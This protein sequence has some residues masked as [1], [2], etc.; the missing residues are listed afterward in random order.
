MKPLLYGAPLSPFVRKVRI[1]MGLKGLEYDSKM[2]V[3]YATPKEYVE[4]SPLRKIPALTINGQ[5]FADSGVICHLLE[6]L[7][8]E[9]SLIPTD[10]IDAARCEWLEKYGDYELSRVLT[11][12]VFFHRVLKKINREEVNE[13]QVQQT[14][15]EK[16]PPLLDYLESQLEGLYFIGDQLTLADISILTQFVSYEHAEGVIDKDKWPKLAH[17]SAEHQKNPVVVEILEQE[18]ASLRK[19]LPDYYR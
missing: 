17:F 11:F 15:N 1:L 14:I 19:L 9:V 5:T 2:I 16:V 13:E 3:P 12:G 4:L 10:P 7:H 8:P 18:I 6:K